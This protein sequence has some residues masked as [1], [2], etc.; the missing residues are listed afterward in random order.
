MRHEPIEG[1][2]RSLMNRCRDALQQVDSARTHRRLVLLMV[3]IALFLDNMLLT[4]VVPIVP[5][6]LM[7]MKAKSV[8][9][10]ILERSEYNCTS[11]KHLVNTLMEAI[12]HLAPISWASRAQVALSEIDFLDPDVASWRERREVG[13]LLRRVKSLAQ[14]CNLN[15]TAMAIEMR[16]SHMGRE[17]FLVGMLFASKSIVQL[18][19]NP[20]VGPL[21]NKIG[22]SLPMFTGF[23]IMFA[24]TFRMGMLATYYTDTKE[25]SRAF[26][27]ALTALALGVL[28]GPTYGGLVYQFVNK[29]APFLMLS[30]LA[31]LDGRSLTFGNMGIAVLE[32]AL[33]MWMKKHMNSDNWEQ[34]IAFLPA[35][36]SYLLSTNIFG[37]FAYKMGYWL[38]AFLGMLLCG[39]CLICV[40]FA[41]TLGHLITPVFGLGVAMGMVDASM[42]PQMGCLVDLRH[43]AVYGSV[44]AIADAAFCLGFAIGP[45]VSGSL[46]QSA[47]FS[48]TIWGIAIV[49]LVY[50]PLLLFLRN[51][52][53]RE[54]AQPLKT[55]SSLKPLGSGLEYDPTEG[56]LK[57]YGYED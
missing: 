32:P 56:G 10:S 5:N 29:R 45:A 2:H 50:G 52:P 12:M 41:R 53:R 15:T 51:P 30:A 28:V 8:V 14:D 20:M 47:G 33:P 35:S 39:L 48:W 46:A 9:K 43:V 11:K 25:R 34:G 13:R 22:Y 26:G 7:T 1:S 31:L 23:L 17:N 18:I 36:I 44:Y 38:S 54:E 21:T 37:R 27:S 42:M 57:P 19:V 3:A 24:S 49:S 6:F 40:P 55:M 4:T 16:E